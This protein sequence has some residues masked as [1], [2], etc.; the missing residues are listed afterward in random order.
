MRLIARRFAPA[1]VVPM[2]R[3]TRVSCTDRSCGP[4]PLLVDDGTVRW[5]AA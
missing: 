3:T 4:A 5:E 2:D 1:R